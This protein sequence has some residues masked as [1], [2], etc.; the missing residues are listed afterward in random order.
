LRGNT[1]FIAELSP[2]DRFDLQCALLSVPYRYGTNMSNIPV[3]TPYLSVEPELIEK[4]RARIGTEGFKIAVCWESKPA[5]PGRSYPLRG[6]HAISQMPGVRLIS[7]QKTYGL[8]QLKELPDGMKVETLGDDFDEGPNAF[9]DTA[10]VMENVDLI[11]TSDTSVAHVAGALRRPT[12]IALK[13]VP[14]WRWL[15][16]RDDNPW[17]P[18]MRLFRQPT[19]AQWDPVLRDMTAALEKQLA[20]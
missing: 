18:G 14:D 7:V 3:E 19:T 15:L 5:G 17:Y 1:R 6:L 4:W 20:K 8:N 9:L 10:A 16:D 12:W 13:Y 2:D 11:I